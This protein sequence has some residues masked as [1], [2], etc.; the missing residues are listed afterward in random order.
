MAEHIKDFEVLL[1]W[2]VHAAC[3]RAHWNAQLLNSSHW[4]RPNSNERRKVHLADMWDRGVKY[5]SEDVVGEGRLHWL[6]TG[7]CNL[8]QYLTQL[9]CG[10]YLD[11]NSQKLTFR[12]VVNRFCAH[13]WH[14]INKQLVCWLLPPILFLR[15]LHLR[16]WLVSSSS[17]IL[18]S[19]IELWKSEQQSAQLWM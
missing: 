15:W 5:V 12:K 18:I 14:T 19:E 10:F 3:C 7:F 8:M 17:Y 11:V 13:L 2:W 6:L 4:I 1:S 16:A 9:S